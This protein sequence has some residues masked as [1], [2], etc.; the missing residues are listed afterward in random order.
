MD[1][2]FDQLGHLRQMLLLKGN[3][4]AL[5]NT[6]RRRN[7]NVTLECDFSRLLQRRD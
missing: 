5:S 7:R 4:A 1:R 3:R 6:R 2:L